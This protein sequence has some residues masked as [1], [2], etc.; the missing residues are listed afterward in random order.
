MRRGFTLVEVAIVLA[1]TTVLL[2]PFLDLVASAYREFRNL[3]VQ[4]DLK[5]EAEATAYR[6]LG[7]AAAGPFRLD[8][9]NHGLSFADGGRARFQD[10][11][12]TMDERVLPLSDFTATW[13]QGVLTLHL[14]FQAPLR[15]GGA[16]QPR[17]F[18]FD[19]PQVGVPR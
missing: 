17:H 18:F 11:V 3:Q 12:L 10:G 13:S 8:S 15:V 7:R 14:A 19:W 1:L 6:L 5:A 9:D 16:A 4:A 2:A